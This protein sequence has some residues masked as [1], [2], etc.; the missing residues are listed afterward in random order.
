M[1]LENIYWIEMLSYQVIQWY[2]LEVF[3]SLFYL[4]S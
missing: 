1:E 2:K 4:C 3:A